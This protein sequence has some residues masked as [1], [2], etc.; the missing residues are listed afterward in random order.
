MHDPDAGPIETWTRVDEVHDGVVSYSLGYRFTRTGDE[1][2][3][4]NALRFR[5]EAELRESLGTAGFTVETVQGDW[6][7]S[8]VTATSPEL[9]VT[10]VR[11]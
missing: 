1:L 9:I 11:R 10:A 7:G 5:S 3:V 8:A 4:P 2:V 6:D